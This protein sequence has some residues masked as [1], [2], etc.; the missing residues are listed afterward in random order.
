MTKRRAPHRQTFSIVSLV[1][2]GLIPV[3]TALFVVGGFYYI[4][5]DTLTRHDEQIKEDITARE[6]L[7]DQFIANTAETAKGISSLA[8]HALV[9]DEKTKQIAETL[10]KVND[11]LDLE[12]ARGHGK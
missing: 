10:G 12:L 9:Q 4:T 5:K 2:L 3:V 8:A 11:K 7:R 1:N 6:K